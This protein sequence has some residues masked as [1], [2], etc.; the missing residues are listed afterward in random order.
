M[1]I[2]PQNDMVLCECTTSSQKQT[3]T[4]FIYKSNDIKLY[5][6]LDVGP[7]VDA[8][9]L[10]VGD[11]VVVNSTGTLAKVGDVEYYLFKEE[12]IAGKVIS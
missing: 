3:N 7:K 6:V 9:Y 5:K 12:N 2:K 1:K 10:A 8:D 11:I 4:G